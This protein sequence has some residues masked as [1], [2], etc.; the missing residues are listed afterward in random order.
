MYR[1]RPLDAESAGRL[2]ISRYPRLAPRVHQRLLDAARGNPL[3]L[4]ELP[5]ALT[6]SQRAA[7]EALP[8]VLPLGERLQALFLSRVAQLP[9]QAQFLLLVA[10]LDGTGD[11]AVLQAATRGTGYGA[12]LDALAPAERDQ[13]VRVDES[14]HRLLFRHP[15]IC[16]AVVEIST[17]AER[18][19][20]HRALAAALHHQ[21]E[22]RAWHLGEACV[23]PDE[24]VAALLEESARDVLRRGDAVGAVRALSRAAALSPRG[25]DRARRLAEAAYV[26][27]DASGA[28]GDVPELLEGARRA[29][30][31]ATVSPHAAAAAAQLVVNGGGDLDTAHRLLVECIRSGGDGHAPGHG[32]DATDRA[33]I[34]ALHLLLLLCAYGG[35]AELW[36]PFDDLVGRLRPGP[37][38]LLAVGAA[39]FGDPTHQGTAVLARLDTLLADA[40]NDP[41]TS[42]IIRTGT[43]CVYTDR[44]STLRTR[45]WRIV[46]QGR[47]GGPVR[48]HLGALMHLCLDD[49]HRGDWDTVAELADEGLGLCDRFGYHFFAWYFQYNAAMVAAARG[50]TER[51]RG[52]ADRITNWALPRGVNGAV[53][54]ARHAHALADLADGDHEGAYQEASAISPAGVLAPHVPH[55]LWVMADL[56][57]AA[58]RTERQSEAAAHVQAMTDAGVAALSPRLA[59]L[60]GGAEALATPDH[61]AALGIFARTLA[62][63]DVERWPFDL[64]RVRLAHGQRLRRSRAAADARAPLTQARH[65]FETLGATPW[66]QRAA[67]ELAAARRPGGTPRSGALTPQEHEVAELAASG[68]T[69]KQIAEHLYISPRTVGAHLY[70]IFPKLGIGSRAALRDALLA[71]EG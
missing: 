56:V 10:T 51:A 5:A 3:A 58:V 19:R 55:A 65:T 50:D 24:R 42:R 44:L 67:K 21:P 37:P 70:Q 32:Y 22:R 17:A 53:A 12:A 41:D 43:A 26:G 66:A 8:T 38:D 52:L 57:E 11:L 47:D 71:L 29:S 54:F 64:A 9:R 48:R 49:F 63:P 30:G 16:S 60:A 13:L 33:L 25:T 45:W 46:R 4:L 20:A 28:L 68:L 34:D 39:A 62:L 35:R 69:N 27:A 18:R 40:E 14:S 1:L 23:E 36:S 31:C 15:L 59:L 2:I 6:G 61:D 7:V